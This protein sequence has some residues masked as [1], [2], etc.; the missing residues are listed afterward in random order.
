M[1]CMRFVK[2]KKGIITGIAVALLLILLI[3]YILAEN[4]AFYRVTY[5]KTDISDILSKP[6]LSYDDRMLI[7]RQTGISPGSV[8]EIF[9]RGNTELIKNLQTLYFENADYQ[10]IYIAF[11][12]TLEER[13]KKTVTPLIPLKKGDILIT[14]NTRTADWGHGHS[15]LLLDNNGKVMLEHMA[16]GKNSVVSVAEYWGTYPS[17][18][19]LRY[20]DEKIAAAAADYANENLVDIPY[21]IF[22]G[23][24]K[25]DK[26]GVKNPT[27]HCSHIVWQAYKSQGIDIDSNKGSIVTPRD[28]ANSQDLKVA[29]IFGINPD[30]YADRLLK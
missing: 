1:I 21:D 15:A 29:Q 14:F 30:G 17:F 10:K 13:N 11:P 26:T 23:L 5:E 18:I 24:V 25:K 8:E 12:V 7:F 9:S 19:V 20:P 3:R 4:S 16:I 2:T 6:Q 22:A 28:I 27:S